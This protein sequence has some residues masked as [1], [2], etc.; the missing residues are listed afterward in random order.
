MTS[1]SALVRALTKNVTLTN[2]S[3]H[4]CYVDTAVQ[5]KIQKL[6]DR[7]KAIQHKLLVHRLCERNKSPSRQ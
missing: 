3:L 4:G 6:C 2:L 1:A 7:N 5:I